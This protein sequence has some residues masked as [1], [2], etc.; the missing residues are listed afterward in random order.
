MIESWLEEQ[1]L[2]T[3]RLNLLCDEWKRTVAQ[4]QPGLRI[5]LGCGSNKK[6]GTLGFDIQ[7]LPGVDCV[8][9]LETQPL[10]LKDR[11]VVYAY[12][13]H[14]LE[15]TVKTESLFQEISRVCADHARLELWT[16]YAW[17]NSA[18][19]FDHK[20]FFA[21]DIYLHICVWYVDFWT[22]ILKARWLLDGFHYVVSQE[23]LSHL[24]ENRISL[25]FALSHLHNI[26]TEF[27][28]HIT[29]LRD[30][31]SVGSPPIRRT[32]STSPFAPRYDLCEAAAFGE[33]VSVDQST[34]RGGQ[35]ISTAGESGAAREKPWAWSARFRPLDYARGILGVRAGGW[36]RGLRDFLDGT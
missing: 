4:E 31:P 22:D 15:H 24:K 33:A 17:S 34:R 25:D 20:T 28:V 1:W 36:L 9:D 14:F 16:P 7:P 12:S 35:Q 18:F 6:Q 8:V 10:P 29:V 21:E 19:V 27:C 26:A 2:L 11:S 23:T 30:D 32:F 13:Y 5:D 3:L